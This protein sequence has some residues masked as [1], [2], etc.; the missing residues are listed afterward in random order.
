MRAIRSAARR[1]SAA[2]NSTVES[3]SRLLVASSRS[4][5]RRASAVVPGS[6]R[7]RA[8]ITGSLG[9]HAATGNVRA[10]VVV[11]ERRRVGVDVVGDAA[12]GGADVELFGVG[13]LGEQEVCFVHGCAL[14]SVDRRGVVDAHMAR[15]DVVGRN[16]L[17]VAGVSVLEVQLVSRPGEHGPAV[18]V[19]YPLF[20]VGSVGES[21][22]RWLW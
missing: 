7:W 4:C 8:L 13:V 9:D 5:R 3:C 20:V 10:V 22:G 16:R 2:V 18:A 17:T 15:L 19:A 11:V 12:A 21:C 6:C 1:C 14:G